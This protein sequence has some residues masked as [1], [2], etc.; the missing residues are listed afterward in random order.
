M[1]A[2]RRP[3]KI[4]QLA[5]LYESVPPKLYGG[6]ERLVAYLTEALIARGHQVTL[7]ASGDSTCRAP[8][9]A[10][11]PQAL[12][13][14]KLN[15][16]G[17]AYQMMM[18]TEA[19]GRTHDFDIIHS[20]LDYWGFPFQKLTSTPLVST[21][22]GRL[23]VPECKQLYQYYR[24]APVVSISDSQRLPHPEL[25]W[26][27]TVHHGLPTEFL[28]YNPKA[29]KYLAFLGRISPEKRPDWAIEVATRAGIPL[30]I[31]A[32]VDD[33]NR[34]YHE[35]EIKPMLSRPGVEFIGEISEAEKSEFLGNAMALL[36]TI[37]WPEPFGL[38]ML[39]AMACGTPVIARPCGSVPEVM[40]DGVTG[41]I[42]SEIDELVSCAQKAGSI[43]R[44]DCRREFETRFTADTMAANYEA[45]YA[46]LLA[47]SVQTKTPRRSASASRPATA[48]GGISPQAE[49]VGVVAAGSGASESGGVSI[50]AL[51]KS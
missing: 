28:K 16:M 41:F 25:N 9:R 49:S 50:S 44:A 51:P 4:A 6:T 2:L 33:A 7:F 13:L 35:T 42:A 17:P 45:I 12:R 21:L 3:L 26:A 37:D 48:N 32:K 38:V 47:E 1:Q 36:F 14:A 34:E 43:S 23:D 40:R 10:V 27:A 18:L 15:Y 20:H 11:Y 5:P 8:L 22:H 31:A 39:E 30:K 19:L 29:G 24:H 46:K